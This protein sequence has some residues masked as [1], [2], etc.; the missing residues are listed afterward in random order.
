[1]CLETGTQKQGVWGPRFSA[2]GRELNR[3]RVAT[4]DA[5]FQVSTSEAMQCARGRKQRWNKLEIAE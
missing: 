5:T 4:S 2:R 3:K 1:V